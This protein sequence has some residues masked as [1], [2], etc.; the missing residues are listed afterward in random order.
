MMI[1][2]ARD[3]TALVSTRVD[4]AKLGWPLVEATGDRGACRGKNSV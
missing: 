1:D 3:L 4:E 2:R